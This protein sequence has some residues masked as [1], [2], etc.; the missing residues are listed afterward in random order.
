MRG[1]YR[2]SELDREWS[3]QGEEGD[4]QF[5]KDKGLLEIIL[6]THFCS[7]S[8][9]DVFQRR[10]RGIMKKLIDAELNF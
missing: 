4:V 1:K 8:E 10:N 3:R 2:G 6:Q 9:K 5:L 7:S